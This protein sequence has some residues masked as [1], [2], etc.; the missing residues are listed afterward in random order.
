MTCLIISL[1]ELDQL[2]SQGIDPRQHITTRMPTNLGVEEQRLLV[3]I[4]FLAK[5]SEEPSIEW[6]GLIQFT[7]WITSSKVALSVGDSVLVAR[8]YRWIMQ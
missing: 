7:I 4:K 1:K 2:I 3:I 5:Q 6:G 8:T